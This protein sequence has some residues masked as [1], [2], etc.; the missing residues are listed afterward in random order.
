MGLDFQS[1]SEN[2][3]VYFDNLQVT[4]ECGPLLEELERSGNRQDQ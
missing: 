2:I 4:H 1:E 3:P